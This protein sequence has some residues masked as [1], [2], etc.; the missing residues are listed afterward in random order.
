MQSWSLA[1]LPRPM[2]V[3]VQLCNC[4][5]EGEGGRSG[6]ETYPAGVDL[7]AAEGIVVGTHLGGCL[8]RSLRGWAD[9][10]GRW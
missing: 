8:G 2:E 9:V 10:V 4:D 1:G 6:W 7:L 5:E 3:L